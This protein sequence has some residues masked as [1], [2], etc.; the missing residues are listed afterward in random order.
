[1]ITL[2]NTVDLMNS[3]DYKDRFIAEY[4]QT[5]IR[6]N[7]LH[8]MLVK[9]EAGT[10]T[11]TPNCP[12]DVLNSQIYYMREYLTQLEVRAELE[13]IDLFRYT[14]ITMGAES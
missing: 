10:L 9:H 11:F 6:Y 4:L 7:N 1:M 2:K 5:K 3:G 8:K 13:G 12:I 14:K